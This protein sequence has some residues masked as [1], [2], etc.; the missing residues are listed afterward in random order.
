MLRQACYIW[1]RLRRCD[2]M[3][4]PIQSIQQQVGRQIN[5][6]WHDHQI[7]DQV[8][9][10]GDGVLFVEEGPACPIHVLPRTP[11][12]VDGYNNP[13]C[14]CLD[15]PAAPFIA[16]APDRPHEQWGRRD[17]EEA[18]HTH[19]EGQ[20]RIEHVF[21]AADQMFPREYRTHKINGVE[22]LEY[23]QSG[24]D[25]GKDDGTFGP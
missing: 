10:A 22:T 15:F 23:E 6:E 19:G 21:R 17:V 4:S 1:N 9:P 25:P 18:Q 11:E 13:G 12:E 8:S 14:E 24:G 3:R 5:G 7:C 20:V 2:W 16:Q